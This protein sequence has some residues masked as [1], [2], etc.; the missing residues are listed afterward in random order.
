MTSVWPRERNHVINSGRYIGDEAMTDTPEPADSALVLSELQR[1]TKRLSLWVLILFI[2][3]SFVVASTGTVGVL[4]WKK[5]NALQ[6]EQKDLAFSL[7]ATD[8]NSGTD[9]VVPQVN[10]IQFLR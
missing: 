5:A 8:I 10:T 3:L 1:K 2:A 9:F 6:R 7:F 4:F